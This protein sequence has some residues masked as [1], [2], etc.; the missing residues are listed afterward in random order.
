MVPP[1]FKESELLAMR[2]EWIVESYT[3]IRLLDFGTIECTE[4]KLMIA[5]SLFQ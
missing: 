4:S 1:N 5:N 2:A 3:T